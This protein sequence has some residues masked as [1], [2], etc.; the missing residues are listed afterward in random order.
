MKC[1][2]AAL[3]EPYVS[4]LE[5]DELLLLTRRRG[6][7]RLERD[8]LRLRPPGGVR[9]LERDTL[10]ECGV[11]ER[12]RDPA[13]PPREA[14]VRRSDRDLERERDPSSDEWSSRSRISSISSSLLKRNLCLIIS[15]LEH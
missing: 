7:V 13:P 9:D 8:D 12:E 3:K 1:N 6:G 15:L 4:R 2:L 11:R 5:D 14:L 10:R